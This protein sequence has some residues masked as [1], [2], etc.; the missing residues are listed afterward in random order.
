MLNGRKTIGIL[1]F[2]I[3][4]YY[5]NELIKYLSQ[6]SE[7]KGYNLL[8]FSA[9]TIYGK[10][11]NNAEGE[12]NIMNL[13]P[14]EQLDAF[15][16]CHDTFESD[17]IVE[18][19]Q[20]MLQKRCQCPIV[21]VRK[22]VEGCY[23][24][25]VNDE[26]S[27]PSLIN[28][29]YE[30]H[31]YE[32]IA[33]MSGPLSHPDAIFRLDKYHET[34][35]S[36]C[37]PHPEEYIFE[38][39]FWKN[40]GTAAATYFSSLAE[41][42][43]AII[44]ANDYMALSLCKGFVLQGYN[45]PHDFAIC[46]YDDVI[47]SS[48]NIPPLTTCKV[49]IDKLAYLAIDT[50]HRLLQ[51]E[52]V[53]TN[54]YTD[55]LTIIRNSCGCQ[56]VSIHDISI[57]HMQQ[58]DTNESLLN[59]SVHNTFTSIA[60]EN[61]MSAEDIG[62]YLALED[63]PDNTRDFYL[64]LGKNGE[65]SFPQ[66]RQ[67]KPGFAQYSQSIYSLKDL[68]P[69]I[70]SS[71][72]TKELLP[73]EAIRQ[74]P[75]SVFFFPIHYLQY[76]FGY[77]AATSNKKEHKNILFHS[78]LAIIGN[79]LE[80]ARIQA[81]NEALLAKLNTLY[82][83]DSLTDLYN[84]RG[85]EQFSAAKLAQANEANVPSMILGIDMDDLKYINDVYGHAQGDVALRTI[86]FAIQEACVMD[87]ICARIGGDEYEVFGYNYNTEMAEAFIDKFRQ[88]LADF[89]DTSNLPYQVNAS[90]GYTISSPNSDKS[91]E[92]YL[93]ESDDLL[94]QNKRKRKERYGNLSKRPE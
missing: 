33:F 93:K 61:L 73:P 1:I 12:Y 19:M 18:K 74:E 77:I 82:V 70:T 54:R 16:L 35:E 46:G 64:C 84:R 13:I 2:D 31:H 52:T 57:C 3:T 23:N 83:Q 85:F 25:L 44:C 91:L 5:Q 55:A 92:Y 10:V 26:E 39:D 11:G 66:T 42:P 6:F 75:M 20:K 94:Y 45:I 67:E 15:I 59:Q 50:I 43:Q 14:L 27:I 51:G 9:F 32:R 41:P 79:T 30:D 4:S 49:S 78:W 72:P 63:Y 86:A 58:I 28:H 21:S 56:T 7:E 17:F 38:G 37:L 76:N 87:E 22:K 89:N 81:R 36:L 65:G 62:D 68:T 24:I 60:L 47:E 90:I 88:Y 80:H 71:F 29:L 69:I 48:A 8:I 40:M 34:M 53:E